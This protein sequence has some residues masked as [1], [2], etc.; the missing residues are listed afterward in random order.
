[1]DQAG[2]SRS[3]LYR[4]IAREKYNLKRSLENC[5][6]PNSVEDKNL[7]S[8]FDLNFEHENENVDVRD[9]YDV[10]G[11][12]LEQTQ[13]ISAKSDL[14]HKLIKW[15]QEYNPTRASV[16][17]LLKILYSEGLNVPISLNGLLKNYNNKITPRTVAPGKYFH[18][19]IEKQL[20]KIPSTA[21]VEKNE[22]LLDIG[23][24]GLPL[25]KSSSETLWPIMGRAVN[26]K[27]IEV[28]LIGTYLGK[29][30]PSNVD[31][32]LHDFILEVKYLRENGIMLHNRQLKF[33]IR[34]F[35]C[36]APARSFM[37]SIVGHNS[38]IG[39]CKCYQIGK[40]IRNVTTFSTKSSNLRTD[41]DFLDRIQPDFH[42]NLHRNAPSELE[43]AAFK[44]ITQ[45][46][47]DAMHLIDLG[48]TRKMLLRYL[49]G[50]TAEQ[51]SPANKN[52]L[53]NKLISLA[54]HIPKEFQRKPR[55][56]DEIL[57]W[58][59][60]EFRQ[61]ILY[62]GPVV[63]KNIVDD[64][65][66]YEFLLLH[67]AY[68]LLSTP[69]NF[70]ANLRVA[71]ELLKLFV[72]NFPLVFG[73]NSV[74]FNVHSILHIINAVEDFGIITNFTAY[75]FENFMQDLKRKI[76]KPSN[77]LE[78][79][80]NRYSEAGIV[81]KEK[82]KGFKKNRTG[83]VVSFQTDGYF[84]SSHPPDNVCCIKQFSPIKITGFMDGD[85]GFIKGLRFK[86]LQN[87][88]QEPL[89]SM[90]ALGV[91]TAEL[92]TEK[93]EEEIFSINDIVFKMMCLPHEEK[94]ILIPLLHSCCEF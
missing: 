48:I 76:R 49:N 23:V 66:Y 1:M 30:K 60:T 37:C 75:S 18:L 58:K 42:K 91:C 36:D 29:K 22:V 84:L 26:I 6:D 53:S 65:F 46:P 70:R 55:S 21:I 9:E 52:E 71:D 74:T 64:N 43:R 5:E 68:R 34:A 50:K 79:I 87:F 54:L 90:P 39:C 3:T 15:Y 56:L 38:L 47:L 7:C 86:N 16:D 13:N 10:Q 82:P 80:S 32:Y 77:I 44:M 31:L 73:E 94:Y 20:R 2:S 61:F 24:D 35:V 14:R 62:T 19:G 25:Y 59:A 11:F 88:F 78:Q 17:S 4:R 83:K 63:M 12:N 41:R 45:F 69:A 51:I 93:E 27:E 40:R 8:E 92:S 28:F 85:G 33:D 89:Q 72:E 81:K 57:K 67:S